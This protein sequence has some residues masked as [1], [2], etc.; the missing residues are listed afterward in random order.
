MNRITKY[1]IK[2]QLFF[3]D[4]QEQTVTEFRMS[5]ET[6]KRPVHGKSGWWKDVLLV[7]NTRYATSPTAN[8]ISG[9]YTRED[10]QKLKVCSTQ[11]SDF[12]VLP[13]DFYISPVGQ[14][15]HIPYAGEERPALSL[16][17]RPVLKTVQSP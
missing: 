14:T 10:Y 7:F 17:S 4:D 16:P 12:R 15:E 8:P 9:W 1:L 3:R 2:P 13:I 6:I 5:G 11:K